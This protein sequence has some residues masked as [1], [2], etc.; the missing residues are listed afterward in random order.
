MSDIMGDKGEPMGVPYICLYVRLLKLKNVELRTSLTPIRN[1]FLG[2]DVPP[3]I[4]FHLLD[5]LS[6]AN[7]MGTLVNK[8]TTSNETN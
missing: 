6:N 3:E 4:L 8:E 2:I 5:K 7:S 1:S